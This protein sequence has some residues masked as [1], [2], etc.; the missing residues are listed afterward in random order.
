MYIIICIG[1]WLN[2]VFGCQINLKIG[3]IYLKY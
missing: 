2:F 1:N 3:G